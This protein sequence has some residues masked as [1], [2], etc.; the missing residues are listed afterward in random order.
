MRIIFTA[1][2]LLM[3]AFGADVARAQAADGQ[4]WQVLRT[5]TGHRGGV[6]SVAFSPDGKRALSGS[7]AYGD[8]LRLWD[9]AT[10]QP[11]K[12]LTGKAL[13]STSVA[14]SPDG[15]R[16]LWGSVDG[17]LRLWD[18]TT[19]QALKILQGHT[20]EIRSVAFSPDGKRALSGSLDGRAD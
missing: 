17:R 10:G 11:L 13:M 14:F 6:N 18:L 8:G 20:K 3:S 15:K 7:G 1:L 12:T 4:N 5:M 19:G 16:A 9:L 2:V